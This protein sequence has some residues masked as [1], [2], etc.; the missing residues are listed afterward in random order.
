MSLEEQHYDRILMTYKMSNL[1]DYT[2]VIRKD[3]NWWIGWIEEVSGV[4]C[5][6]L[7]REE[8]IKNLK[9]ALAEAIELKLV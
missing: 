2:V 9:E 5:Q 8:L 7:T 1:N 6:S 4:N 3:G